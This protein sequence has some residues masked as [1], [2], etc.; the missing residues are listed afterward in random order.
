MR[1]LDNHLIKI[2][3]EQTLKQLEAAKPEDKKKVWKELQEKSDQ[4]KYLWIR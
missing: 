3:L 4:T 2:Q 1:Y